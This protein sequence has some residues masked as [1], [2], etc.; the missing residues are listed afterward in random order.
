MISITFFV[1][2]TLPMQPYLN[3]R[4]FGAATVAKTT[5]FQNALALP[6]SIIAAPLAGYSFDQHG[7]YQWVFY[8]CGVMMAI[9]SLTTLLLKHH[10]KTVWD[11]E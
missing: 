6:I 7:N 1:G 11:K 2:G 5:G 3:S 10:Q 9:S 8:G 4:F